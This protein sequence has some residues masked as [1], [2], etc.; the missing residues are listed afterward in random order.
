MLHDP[1]GMSLF[2]PRTL[3]YPSTISCIIA[4]ICLTFATVNGSCSPLAP[5]RCTRCLQ[6]STTNQHK[7]SALSRTA[8]GQDMSRCSFRDEQTESWSR[9]EEA[10]SSVSL[11]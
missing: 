10:L 5:L 11:L 3:P 1:L 4:A 2:S 8:R 6:V 7:Q 9:A